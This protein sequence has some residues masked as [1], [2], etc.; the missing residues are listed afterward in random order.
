MST[1]APGCKE[2]D[3]VPKVSFEGITPFRTRNCRSMVSKMGLMSMVP[4][5]NTLEMPS[6]ERCTN[7]MAVV[8]FTEPG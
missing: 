3:V 5:G 6:Y 2:P 4:P 8:G 1:K 7:S